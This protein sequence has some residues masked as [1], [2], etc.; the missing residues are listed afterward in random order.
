MKVRL[1]NIGRKQANETVEVK[2]LTDIVKHASKH[3]ASKGVDYIEKTD[4]YG[5]ITAGDRIVGQ[6]EIIQA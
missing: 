6:Y 3:L 2:R 4:Y 1:I 5:Y